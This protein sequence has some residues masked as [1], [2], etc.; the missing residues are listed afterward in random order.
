MNEVSGNY[1]TDAVGVDETGKERKG[2]K[3]VGANARLK[4]E[5]GDDHGPDAEEGH[6]TEQGVTR[7]VTLGAASTDDVQRRLNSV[8]DADNAALDQPP[9]GEGE[10]IDERG[11]SDIRG[12]AKFREHALPPEAAA[13]DKASNGQDGNN[14]ENAL[15][16]AVDDTKGEGLGVV[17][18]PCLNVKGKESWGQKI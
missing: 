18:F 17:G 9:L 15:N 5:I 8:E 13:A 3:M 12:D 16:R 6:K 14:G 4:C 10:L 7:S 2:D 11:N 1:L